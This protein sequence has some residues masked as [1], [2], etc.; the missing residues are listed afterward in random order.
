MSTG[1]PLLITDAGKAEIINAEQS[2][3]ASVKLAYLAFGTGQYTPTADMTALQSEFKRFDTKAGGAISKNTIHFSVHDNSADTYTVYEVGVFTENGT[4]FA[5][6]SQN[7]VMMEKATSGEVMIAADFIVDEID[8]QNITFGETSFVLNFATTEAAGIVEL[9][10]ESEAKAGTDATKAIT[11]KTLDATIDAHD[12]IVHKSGAEAINGYK[13]FVGDVGKRN[14]SADVSTVPEN[15]TYSSFDFSDKNNKKYASVVGA[16]YNNGDVGAILATNRTVNGVEYHSQI[17]VRL[18]EDGTSY[19][20]AP[21]PA[22]GDNSTKIATTAFV[23]NK[24]SNY[25]PLAG[26]KMTGT[27][28]FSGDGK[29]IINDGSSG[30]SVYSSTNSTQPGTVQ[31][32]AGDTSQNSYINLYSSQ[33]PTNPGL[34]YLSANNGVKQCSFAVHPEGN[35]TINSKK[36]TVDGDC[37]PLSGGA[38]TATKA[39]TRD[40]NDSYISIHG[41]T[42]ENND[43]AQADFCGANHSSMPGGFQIHARNS[44]NDVIL[45]GLIDGTLTWNSKTVLTNSTSMPSNASGVVLNGGTDYESGAYIRVYGKEHSTYPGWFTLGASDGT[46]SSALRGLPDGTLTWNGSRLIT[47]GEEQTITG[48]KS[49]ETTN[50]ITLDLIAKEIDNTTVPESDVTQ[51]VINIKDQLDNILGD[52]FAHKLADG[53]HQIGLQAKNT[54]WMDGAGYIDNYATIKLGF[55]HESGNSFIDFSA[56]TVSIKNSNIIT[57]K[58]LSSNLKSNSSTYLATW[59]KGQSGYYTFTNGL[60]LNWGY[61]SEG[62]TDATFTYKKAFSSA[63]SYSACV[64]PVSSTAY[65]YPSYLKSRSA[66]NCVIRRNDSNKPNTLIIAIGY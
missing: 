5:L 8:P 37:L 40:V 58:T 25:L 18:D 21:T 23:N 51:Y 54:I 42:G 49:F 28:E 39:I 63:T 20:T 31:V 11:P 38:M 2:G 32:R 29:G 66:T 45:R 53:K 1:I 46:N 30:I 9:A 6:A 41:G 13:C 7:T 27:I 19:A 26:G 16:T 50:D 15:N 4:L 59:S 10:T 17:H 64:C 14:N 34:V 55:P 36:V 65:G 47:S 44:E 35:A 48:H 33:N 61:L 57:E 60:I 12:N 43:G 56:G 22:S 62:G 3:T 24:A 52:L